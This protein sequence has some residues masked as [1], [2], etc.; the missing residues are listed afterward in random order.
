MASNNSEITQNQNNSK[1][2]NVS[3][4]LV[5]FITLILG[6]NSAVKAF[7]STF[8]PGNS[9]NNLGLGI[10]CFVAIL[11]SVWVWRKAIN[12]NFTT[13]NKS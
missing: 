3:M 1:G 7:Y 12:P 5:I 2:L 6:L 11:I 10:I 13:A 9:L 8:I 4:I